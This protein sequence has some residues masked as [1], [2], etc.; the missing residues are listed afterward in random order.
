METTAL[1][2]FLRSFC[3][4]S[5]WKFAVFWKVRLGSPMILNWEVGYVHHLRPIESMEIIAKNIFGN[6]M[7][8]TFLPQC[9][10]SMYDGRS[11][12]HPINL[13]VADMSRLQY[14]WGE[15]VVGEV[16]C[17]GCH[18]WVTIEDI[19]TCVAM[20]YKCPEE[21]L[22]QFAAGIKT[23]L[24]VPLLPHGVLQLGSLEEIS[25]YRGSGSN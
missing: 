21:W 8:D 4:N 2:Q 13:V 1:M 22:L 9:E 5:C 20:G 24:L 7:D 23:I 25:G 17:T 14:A 15:G 11:G 16:A 6:T 10:A 12:E 3:D 19:L 18:C